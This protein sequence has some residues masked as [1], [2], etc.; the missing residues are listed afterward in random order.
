MWPALSTRKP[1]ETIDRF[2]GADEYSKRVFLRYVSTKYLGEFIRNLDLLH[3]RCFT[4]GDGTGHLYQE[5]LHD[6]QPI[7][8]RDTATRK[9][10]ASGLQKRNSC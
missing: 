3:P 7:K 1:V 5:I 4:F 2:E 10:S 9:R 8:L 6:F